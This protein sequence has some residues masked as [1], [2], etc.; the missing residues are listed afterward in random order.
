MFTQNDTPGELGQS[1]LVLICNRFRETASAAIFDKKLFL[2]CS[3]A[4]NIKLD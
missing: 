4:I 3:G 2:L 1:F